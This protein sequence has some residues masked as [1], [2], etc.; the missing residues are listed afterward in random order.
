MRA[1]AISYSSVFKIRLFFM[2]NFL[3]FVLMAGE[4]CCK[5]VLHVDKT[6]ILNLAMM[7]IMMH[8]HLNTAILFLLLGFLI[9]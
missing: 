5:L 7:T 2:E 9:L 3:F 8:V 4:K 1:I 6:I